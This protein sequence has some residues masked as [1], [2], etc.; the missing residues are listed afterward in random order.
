MILWIVLTFM[1][2][3]AVSGLTLALVL[4]R[5]GHS[6]A[7]AMSILAAQLADVELQ[8]AAGDLS[9]GDAGP[10]RNEIRRR[11]LAEGKEP[12]D[13]A[14]PVA[15]NALPWLAIGIAGVVALAATG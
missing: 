4:R 12:A 13:S 9:V 11:I 6:R 5:A 7:T 2:A 1:V 3:V 8:I 10:L 15:A 14:K